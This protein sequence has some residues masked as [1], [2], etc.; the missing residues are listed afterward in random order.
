MKYNYKIEIRE[1]KTESY[2]LFKLSKELE[3]VEMFLNSDIQGDG[4]I[5]EDIIRSMDMVIAGEKEL[6]NLSGNTCFIN[7]KKDFTI[8]EML[9]YDNR[10][11]TIETNE[12]RLLIDMFLKEKRKFINETRGS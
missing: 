6:I 9:Y 3:P 10:F 11:I 12:L 5:T 2:F 7:V 8:V 1:H 4:K